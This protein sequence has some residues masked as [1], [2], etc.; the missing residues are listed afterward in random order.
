VRCPPGEPEGTPV[1]AFGVGGC[2][3]TY[4]REGIDDPA[5]VLAEFAREADPRLY[6]AIKRPRFASG[7]PPGDYLLVFADARTVSVSGDGITWLDRLCP[8]DR[9]DPSVYTSGDFALS[10]QTYLLPPR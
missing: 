4:Y 9:R 1:S 3:G 5:A 2:E 7:G 8:V 10:G 6:A